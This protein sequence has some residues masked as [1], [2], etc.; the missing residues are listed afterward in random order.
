MTVLDDEGRTTYASLV[1][2]VNKARHA[3]YVADSPVLSDAEYDTLYHR[4]LDLETQYP[5]LVT[6][7]SRPARWVVK[8]L[9]LSLLFRT[10][11][12]CTR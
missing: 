9:K 4:L 11:H 5:Q 1:D 6:A 12:A 7:D 2:T 10:L 3:Y 8:R